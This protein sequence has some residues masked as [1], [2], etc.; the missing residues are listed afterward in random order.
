MGAVAKDFSPPQS[1]QVDCPRGRF[2]STTEDVSPMAT[3]GQGTLVNLIRS[4]RPSITQ[5][6]GDHI[7]ISHKRG[8]DSINDEEIAKKGSKEC[9]EMRHKYRSLEER[10]LENILHGSPIRSQRLIGHSNLRYQWEKYWKTRD[11]LIKMRKPIRKYYERTNNL[12]QNYI[13][14]DRLLDSSLPH[15]LLN[16]YGDVGS[17]TSLHSDYKN[18]SSLTEAGSE[19]RSVSYLEVPTKKIKRTPR[20]IYFKVSNEETPLLNSDSSERNSL[21]PGPENEE[22]ESGD[23]IVHIAIYVNLIANVIL[24]ITKITT[25]LLTNSLSVLA[26]LVDA[27]LDLLSTVIVWTTS[28]LIEKQDRYSYPIG[29]RRLE[30][31]GV[32]IFSVIM[33]TSFFQVGLQCITRLNSDDHNIIQLTMPAIIPMS[34]TI[35]IKLM[36]WFWCRMVKNSGVQALAQ[37][38]M[39]DVI[40]NTFSIIFPLVGFYAKLWWF[41]ALGGLLLSLYIVVNWSTTSAG[42]IRNLTG[43]TATADERNVL[44]YLTMRF[45][46]TIKQIQGLQAYHCGDKLN[47]EV[48]VVLDEQMTL[49]DS[50]DLGE[51]LQY[52]L[53][54]VPIVDRAFVHQDYAG[55]NLPTHMEQQSG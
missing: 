42:H 48:D 21:I 46:N 17:Y 5:H 25:I 32:L 22:S 13:Y 26:S 33:I 51:S 10:R 47:V 45:A 9:D 19:S 30:P 55:W 29:R 31:L 23:R 50:H 15:D 34:A 18:L 24:L 16:E 37:D 36:C 40:F 53:E 3:H 38:A 28:K 1:Q 35:I 44:L 20:E 27:A 52:V 43:A 54:S 8:R 39:T 2:P 12:I 4:S 11:E 6:N 14:I 49:R 41:D 7:F